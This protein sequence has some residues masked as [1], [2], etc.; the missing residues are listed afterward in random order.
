MKIFLT[1]EKGRRGTM[2]SLDKMLVQDKKEKEDK[3]RKRELAAEEDEVRCKEMVI[4]D[5]STDN[6][7]STESD[8][9]QHEP[10]SSTSRNHSVKKCERIEVLSPNLSAALDRTKTT[11]RMAMYIIANT[12]QSF[13]HNMSE[14]ILNR[15][16]ITRKRIEHR[17]TKSL[18]VQSNFKP[19]SCLVVHC[20]SKLMKDI[21]RRSFIDRLPVLVTVNCISQLLRIAKIPTCS[22]DAQ[23]NAVLETLQQ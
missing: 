6:T 9:S 8:A 1:L 12:A 10:V 22:G 2:S 23:A 11:D 3:A 15:S 17:S 19:N 14:S 4:L 7:S 18:E 20:D 16:T 5:S 21:T 13:G